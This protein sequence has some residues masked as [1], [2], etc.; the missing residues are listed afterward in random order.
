METN[1]LKDGVLTHHSV[2]IGRVT[3]S[4][5]RTRAIELAVI[6][7]RSPHEASKADWER[8]K[9]ELTGTSGGD[10]NQ[11]LL[12]AA[13]ESARWDPLPGFTGGKTPEAPGEDEDVEG[14]SD[15]TRLVGEGMAGAESDT[16]LQ[17]AKAAQSAE[18]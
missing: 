9:I 5:V 2:G 12:E 13:P 7:G 18:A 15:C 11:D 8:A 10:S 16:E 14:N 3:R 17:A 4:M 6:D 1:P